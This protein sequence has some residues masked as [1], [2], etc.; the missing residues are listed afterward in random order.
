MAIS[1]RHFKLISGSIIEDTADESLKL[2][3]VQTPNIL[4]S[5]HV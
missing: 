3:A 1:F 4:L 5:V 2:P